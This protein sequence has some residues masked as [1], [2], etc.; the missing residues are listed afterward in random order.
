[1]ELFG[2]VYLGCGG[3][4]HTTARE[5]TRA[6]AGRIVSAW[7]RTPERA[8]AF[9]N[10]FGGTAYSTVEEAILAPGVDGV[11]IAVN[12]DAHADLMRLCIRHHKPVLCEKPFTVNAP[13]ARAVLDEA[14][15]EGVYVS[16]AM[17]TWHNQVAMKVRQWLRDGRIGEV[18]RVY[19]C[20]SPDLFATHPRLRSPQM[21]GGALMDIGVYNIRYCYELF[22]LPERV[23]CVDW[24]LEGG[25]DT[26][27]TVLMRYPGFTAENII[28]MDGH[29]PETCEIE[30][31]RGVIRVPLFHMAS[32]AVLEC[33]AP[34]RFED[35]SPHYAVQFRQVGE[36]I[37]AGMKAGGFIPPRGTVEVMAL[38][39]QCRERMGLRY[40]CEG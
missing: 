4:A 26:H 14:A 23:E 37:R 15:R 10:E 13:E 5:L 28:G 38:M 6:G 40:P 30:G 19:C 16:E 18:K 34:E 17:W 1:M 9:V 8:V 32:E 2:W 20:F 31:T 22:G 7:N 35:P 24:A 3:I 39:D 25:V 12:P 29:R 27:E 36:E 33:D 21:I 11:Y